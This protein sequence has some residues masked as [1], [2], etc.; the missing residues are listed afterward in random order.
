MSSD[1]SELSSMPFVA[2]PTI[3]RN[4]EEA[5]LPTSS[6]RSFAL[7]DFDLKIHVQMGHSITQANSQLTTPIKICV[8]GVDGSRACE[9][10]LRPP[11]RPPRVLALRPGF[12]EDASSTSS[13]TS[14]SA[15][16]SSDTP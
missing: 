13:I 5:T 1:P 14:S 12:F 16:S 11:L 8:R 3:H 6:C 2:Q 10:P 4:R 7:T 9:P 15:F